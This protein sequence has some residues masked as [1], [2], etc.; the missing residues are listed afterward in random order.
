MKLR[1]YVDEAFAVLALES[2][3]LAKRVADALGQRT[4]EIEVDG[5]VFVIAS[6]RRRLLTCARGDSESDVYARTTVETLADVLG[7][8][9]LLHDALIDDRVHL[10]GAL[11]TLLELD[12]ALTLFVNAAV[13]A[14]SMAATWE[15]FA[16]EAGLG[17]RGTR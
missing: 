1:P 10:R 9:T 7:G 6:E 16:D 14:P 4:I 15:R 12:D 3:S 2:S 5:E 13:R 8:A 11:A 17:S